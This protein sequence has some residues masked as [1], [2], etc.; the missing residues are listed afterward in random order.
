MP[1]ITIKIS[2]YKPGIIDPPAFFAYAVAPS[3]NW[4]VLDALEQIRIHQAPSLMYRRA[5]HHASC[6]SCAC[7]I[8]SVERLACKTL[9]ADLES[10]VITLEPL[11]C[12]RRMGDLVTQRSSLFQTI[13]AN[14]S[15][16]QTD[17]QRE[18]RVMVLSG[19]K[20][21]ATKFE[22]C[23]EC[24]CC[25][26]ACPVARNNQRFIGPA[27]LAAINQEKKKSPAA[28]AELLAL[29]ATPDGEPL[30]RRAL[31]CSRVCP[32]A[33]YPAKHILELRNQRQRSKAKI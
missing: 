28:A 23:I 17:T 25:V 8:N 6:G 30:C 4:T 27:A 15:Y 5:C 13:Q 19:K 12:F 24:G 9:L 18:D 10:P 32:A 26:S 33:V 3:K 7:T 20:Q 14:W 2:R 29:A 21:P 11:H 22:G 31:V 1:D 16:L